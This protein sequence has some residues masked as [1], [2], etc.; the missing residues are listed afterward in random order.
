MRGISGASHA[1]IS[2]YVEIL[3]ANK[4]ST[5]LASFGDRALAQWR[6]INPRSSRAPQPF[7]LQAAAG[8]RWSERLSDRNR[9]LL[10]RAIHRRENQPYGRAMRLYH[11]I[12]FPVS[13]GRRFR[14]L[15]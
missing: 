11:L 6:G 9:D 8:R 14:A 2:T 13:A 4:R 15:N 5:G 12:S 10:N 1:G 3:K 7:Q